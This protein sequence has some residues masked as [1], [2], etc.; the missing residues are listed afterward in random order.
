MLLV[1]VRRRH[2][3]LE[4]STLLLVSGLW[5][6]SVTSRYLALARHFADLHYTCSPCAAGLLAYP[7]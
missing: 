6:G 7:M 3:Q 4:M 5:L 1:D 2:L